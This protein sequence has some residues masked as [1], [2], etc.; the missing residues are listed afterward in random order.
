MS[1]DVQDNCRIASYGFMTVTQCSGKK[2][3]PPDFREQKEDGKNNKEEEEASDCSDKKSYCSTYSDHCS[4]GKGFYKWM[5]RNCQKTC[6]LCRGGDEDQ[7]DGGCPSGTVMCSDGACKHE[8]MCGF[9]G[10]Q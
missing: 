2:C 5:T 6:G 8:H 9:R 7:Q 4:A 1:R 10:L 3:S